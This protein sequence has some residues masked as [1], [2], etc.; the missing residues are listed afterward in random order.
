M[1][2]PFIMSIIVALIFTTVVGF[3]FWRQYNMTE[4]M[5]DMNLRIDKLILEKRTSQVEES[6]RLMAIN[7]NTNLS[8]KIGS[9][10][11]NIQTHEKKSELQEDLLVQ[12]D[13]MKKTGNQGL[14][15]PDKVQYS[16]ERLEE[17]AER[18]EMR[19]LARE[20]VV[21]SAR[22]RM[23]E[24][25]LIRELAAE[26]LMEEEELPREHAAEE[27]VE[28]VEEISPTVE[29]EG[30]VPSIALLSMMTGAS[31]LDSSVIGMMLSPEAPVHNLEIEE[32]EN[33]SESSKSDS[34]KEHDDEEEEGLPPSEPNDE[35]NLVQLK[36]PRRKTRRN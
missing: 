9:L 23:V 20:R 5:Y 24:E 13:L 27:L 17:Q 8:D 31:D 7:R 32:I 1:E 14:M 36:R 11:D 4:S 12:F 33:K 2:Q 16:Q 18:Q 22:E 19:E 6:R 10:S 34:N 25:E 26:E 21:E 29:S 35:I 30:R 28:L 15:P 3:M